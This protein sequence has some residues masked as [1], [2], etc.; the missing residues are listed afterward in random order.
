[1][2]RMLFLEVDVDAELEREIAERD[3]E[4]RRLSEDV[5]VLSELFAECSELIFTQS[6]PLEIAESNVEKSEV[7]VNEAQDELCQAELIQ[8]RR[9]FKG[10]KVEAGI[11]VV[12]TCVGAIGFLGGPWIGVPSTTLALG[13]AATIIAIKRKIQRK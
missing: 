7:S 6:E 11:V 10:T 4:I 1:M 12:A 2:D 3:R 13:A 8:E 9:R 5:S